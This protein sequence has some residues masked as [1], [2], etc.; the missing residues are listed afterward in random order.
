[1]F[2]ALDL[3]TITLTFVLHAIVFVWI[4]RS[5]LTE[6][7][8]KVYSYLTFFTMIVIDIAV[9]IL[10]I[11]YAVESF[12]FSSSIIGLLI[13]SIILF[14]ALFFFV[15]GW[16]SVW[17]L[18]RYVI[19][20]PELYVESDGQ[21][22]QVVLENKPLLLNARSYLIMGCIWLTFAIIGWSSSLPDPLN[23]NSVSGLIFVVIVFFVLVFLIIDLLVFRFLYWIEN[24]TAAALIRSGKFKRQDWHKRP[25]QKWWKNNP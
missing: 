17:F 13:S 21:H 12:A 25:Y 9:F 3:F 11:A 5:G 16:F 1:M 10:T 4:Q 6:T 15:L 23:T 8:Y 22:W 19:K 7:N 20:H 24:L 14:Q 2:F 18:H